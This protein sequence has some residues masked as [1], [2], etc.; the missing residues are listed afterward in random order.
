MMKRP[1]GFARG[2]FFVQRRG[3]W[4]RRCAVYTI[5]LARTKREKN[6]VQSPG[7]KS[8]LEANEVQHAPPGQRTFRPSANAAS[9]PLPHRTICAIIQN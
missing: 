1:P 9:F 4:P 2:S 5:A 8:F 6:P 3:L 7:G